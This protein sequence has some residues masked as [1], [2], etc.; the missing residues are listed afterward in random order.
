M[1]P[2]IIARFQQILP[3]AF[4][5][6]VYGPTE[7]TVMGTGTPAALLSSSSKCATFVEFQVANSAPH[8]DVNVTAEYKGGASV[9]IGRPLANY[10]AYVLDAHL[11]LLPVGVPGE[12]MASGI[13]VARGYLKRP[14]L[15]AEKF[16]ANPYCGGR[17]HHERLY[18]TGMGSMRQIISHRHVSAAHAS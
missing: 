17:M 5:H 15:T 4:L 8:A 1:P 11:Q 14:E 3:H 2:P 13:Q 10:H 12:I 6:N 9:P 16:I 7:T 18:R